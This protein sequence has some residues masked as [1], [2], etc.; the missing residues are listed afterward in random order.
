MKIGLIGYGKMGKA[1]EKAALERGHEICGRLTSKNQEISQLA[2]AD[3]CIDFTDPD[4]VW[5]TV[6]KLAPLRKNIVIGTTDPRVVCVH[7]E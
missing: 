3:V 4:A 5:E 1:V 7:P 2:G 6:N